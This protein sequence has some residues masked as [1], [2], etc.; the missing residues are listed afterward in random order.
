MVLSIAAA[1]PVTISPT[2]ASIRAG[3][4]KQFHAALSGVKGPVTWLVNGVAGGNAALGTIT[5]GGLFSAP[6][7]DPGGALTIRASAGTPAVF[8]D[9]IVTW[10]NPEPSLTSLVPSQVNVGTF[11]VTLNGKNFATASTVQLNGSPVATTFMSST[12]LSFQTTINTAGSVTVTVTN[13]APGPSTSSARTLNVVPPVSVS[14]GAKA[15]VRLGA[16]RKFA[17]TVENAQNKAVV[18]SVNGT[19]GGSATTGTIAPDGTYTAPLI[20]PTGGQVTV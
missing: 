13:P 15:S 9:A 11:T 16:T 5:S 2:Q 18:W 19:L 10:L 4:T 17:A 3:S 6:T 12:S 1:P 7:A 20:M 14:M 8:A